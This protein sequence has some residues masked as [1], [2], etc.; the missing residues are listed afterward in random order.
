MAT[1]SQKKKDYARRLMNLL[2]ENSKVLLISADNVGSKHF[3]DVRR[4]LRGEATILMGKNT[5][6]R[7]CLRDPETLDLGGD[8]IQKKAS[9]DQLIYHIRQNIGFV[10]TNGDL[11]SLKNKIANNLVGAAAK[12]G[13]RAPCDVFVPKGPTGMDPTQTSFFQAL[14]IPTMINRGQIEIKSDLQLINQ[15]ERVG[16]S[17]ATLL[18]K[19][20]IRPFK[21]GL[22]VLWVYE[23][24]TVY[25]ASL[26][27]VGAD[28][29]AEAFKNGLRDIAAI[30]LETNYATSAVVPHAIADGFR[31]LMAVAV[32]TD[33]SFPEAEPLKAF[34][35]DPSAFVV[36]PTTDGGDADGG[37]DA[38][39]AAESSSEADVGA[40][41]L[42]G[43]DEDY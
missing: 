24:D 20:N 38:A 27:D 32:A 22:K 15:G 42:F 33:Y 39:A 11:V 34:L 10:F 21:Y 12:A 30:S 8:P 40:G 16:A 29:I 25:D 28:D 6:I 7:R 19:L 13:S 2:S 4:D 43:D 14:N 31:S 5:M 23:E 1:I 41:G 26:L 9:W 18:Q 35:A 37:A 36:A 3:Q 17:E